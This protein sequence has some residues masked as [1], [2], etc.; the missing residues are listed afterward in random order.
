ME[1]QRERE[2][3]GDPINLLRK[4][5]L[6]FVLA[7]SNENQN[8]LKPNNSTSH[9]LWANTALFCLMGI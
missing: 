8:Y 2:R 5:Q 7:S 6:S 4:V 3:E 1:Y 9:L